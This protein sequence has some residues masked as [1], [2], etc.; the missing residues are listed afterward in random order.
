[1]HYTSGG[2]RYSA[3]S[4]RRIGFLVRTLRERIA[5][6]SADGALEAFNALKREY[7]GFMSSCQWQANLRHPRYRHVI[8]GPTQQQWL[9]EDGWEF[10]NPGTSDLTVRRKHVAVQCNACRGSGQIVSRARCGVCSGR[11]RVPNPAAQAGQVAGAVGGVLGALG[12]R[13]RGRVAPVLPHVSAT[14]PCSTCNGSGYVR[15]Q[16]Q[17]RRCSGSGRVVR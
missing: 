5:Q 15:Q 10:V 7:E 16:S 3:D 17:C 8:S 2:Y 13:R 9:A 1:M 6:N 12:G 11:G 4:A 14:M